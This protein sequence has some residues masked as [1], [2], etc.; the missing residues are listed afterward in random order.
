MAGRA[1]SDTPLALAPSERHLA[2]M[3]PPA[4]AHRARGHAVLAAAL[5]APT[6]LFG[7]VA[8]APSDQPKAS[9]AAAAERYTAQ[10][11]RDEAA[12]KVNRINQAEARGKADARATIARI[13]RTERARLKSE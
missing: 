13:E 1:P 10:L 7:A 3:F 11:D 9:E 8:C 6:V 12:Q 4:F 5:L 2:S